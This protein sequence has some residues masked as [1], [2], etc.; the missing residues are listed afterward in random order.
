MKDIQKQRVCV[1]LC[2]KRGEIFHGDVFKELQAY[3][4]DCLSRKQC[5]GDPTKHDR[6]HQTER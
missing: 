1:K 4:E 5:H 2:S 3:W 6:K